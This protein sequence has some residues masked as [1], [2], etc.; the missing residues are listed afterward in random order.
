LIFY[1]V[2]SISASTPTLYHATMALPVYRV[3]LNPNDKHVIHGGR[4]KMLT[5]EE[6]NVI[7][8]MVKNEVGKTVSRFGLGGEEYEI[9]STFPNIH[10]IHTFVR[11]LESDSVSFDTYYTA[12][13]S[14]KAAPT[15]YQCS[16][17]MAT[18]DGLSP[19][20]HIL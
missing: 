1:I 16:P 6:A 11:G 8:E 5:T 2:I 12:K 14:G 7:R 20:N 3:I 13:Y 4:V 15:T 10:D 18:C 9:M 17:A 19:V